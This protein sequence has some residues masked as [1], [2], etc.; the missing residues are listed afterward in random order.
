MRYCGSYLR[1]LRRRSVKLAD[2]STEIFG[3]S[4]IFLFILNACGS[5]RCKRFPKDSWIVLDVHTNFWWGWLLLPS[6]TWGF[7]P[8]NPVLT[9][10]RLIRSAWISLNFFL[11][12]F[13][14][15]A[16]P[17]AYGGPYALLQLY[18]YMSSSVHCFSI[19][20]RG[21]VHCEKRVR[22]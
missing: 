17:S 16:T 14:K 22:C 19:S 8:F 9:I 20:V 13:F 3:N 7:L 11:F 6:F 21:C 18:S 4:V 12:L 1:V 15:I 5:S 2:S 10:W